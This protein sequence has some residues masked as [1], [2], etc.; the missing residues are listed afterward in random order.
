MI[1]NQQSKRYIQF[2]GSHY[3]KLLQKQSVD[4]TRYFFKKDIARLTKRTNAIQRGGNQEDYDVCPICLDT[5]LGQCITIAPCGHAVCLACM[6][7]ECNMRVQNHEQCRCPLC[8]EAVVGPPELM[9]GIAPAPPPPVVMQGRFVTASIA[10]RVIRNSDHPV[11]AKPSNNASP[12]LTDE[13]ITNEI[14]RML[15]NVFSTLRL[16]DPDNE[17]QL[18]DITPTITERNEHTSEYRIPLATVDIII[19]MF[20]STNDSDQVRSLMNGVLSIYRNERNRRAF[21]FPQNPARGD[22]WLWRLE[23]DDDYELHDLTAYESELM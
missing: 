15:T 20:D 10:A 23:L 19:D 7:T 14:D 8:R 16:F 6:T 2:G 9:S 3:K 22:T 1:V 12:Q 11:F 5:P 21:K 18:Q 13:S 4:G 17:I